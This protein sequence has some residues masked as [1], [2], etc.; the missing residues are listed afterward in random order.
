MNFPF[1]ELHVEVLLLKL[2]RVSALRGLDSE[3]T[4]MINNLNKSL[5]EELYTILI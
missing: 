4:C 5:F 3:L 1:L 2:M